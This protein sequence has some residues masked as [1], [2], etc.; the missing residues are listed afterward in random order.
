[1]E[2]EDEMDENRNAAVA[3]RTPRIRRWAVGMK[4]RDGSRWLDP[5]F[6][7]LSLDLHWIAAIAQ[8]PRDD[9]AF[10]RFGPAGTDDPAIREDSA[11]EWLLA[12]DPALYPQ[13]LW[14]AL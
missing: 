8:L 3:G 5:Y 6:L 9:L 4:L 14:L 2:E 12:L 13:E 7:C 11:V 10:L 1:M